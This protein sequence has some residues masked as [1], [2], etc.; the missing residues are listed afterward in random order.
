MTI[1]AFLTL[2]D[3]WNV[4]NLSWALTIHLAV[5]FFNVHVIIWCV[6]NMCLH[7][8]FLYSICKCRYKRLF[9]SIQ[10][11]PNLSLLS[12][13][14]EQEEQ[15]YSCTPDGPPAIMAYCLLF[16]IN[17]E[18]VISDN[19]KCVPILL[20]TGE[21]IHLICTYIY[22]VWFAIYWLTCENMQHHSWHPF[23]NSLNIRITPRKQSRYLVNW[24]KQ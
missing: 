2:W 4:F 9:Y 13:K 8:L 6:L 23:V 24:K 16:S 17:P 7:L 20:T 11:D 15:P 12:Y 10:N 1:R 18:S 5:G 19:N 14:E 22:F 21:F 3:G